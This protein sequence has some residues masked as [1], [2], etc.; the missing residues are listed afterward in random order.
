VNT[1]LTPL[2]L[3]IPA[4][5]LAQPAPQAPQPFQ[6]TPPFVNQQ[7]NPSNTSNSSAGTA[8]QPLNKQNN[9]PLPSPVNP[10]AAA[11]YEK[12]SKSTKTM[13]SSNRVCEKT[14]YG[15]SVCTNGGN[16]T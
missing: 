1:K 6:A 9:G 16:V 5:A 10:V 14:N 12:A 11:A 2:A 7:V 3:L 8:A 4:V 15:G 13:G